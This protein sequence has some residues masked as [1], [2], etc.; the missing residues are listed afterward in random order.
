MSG[1]PKE[2]GALAGARA[3]PPLILVLFHFCEQSGYFHT[4][5][6][7]APIGKGYLWVEF[8]FALSGFVLI[9]AYGARAHT[10]WRPVE[11]LR[12][13]ATRLSRLYPLHL[14]TLLLLA[15]IVVVARTL[16][17]H[18][19]F[20]SVFDQPYHP[21]VTG[22]TFAANLAL[23][24][25]WN[26]Y[27]FLSWNAPSWFVSVEFLLCLLFP[28]FV[29]FSRGGF[30]RGL[31]LVGAGAAGLAAL[32]TTSTQGLDLT[33]HN[34]IYR[35][36]AGF[37]AGIGFAVIFRSLSRSSIRIPDWLL[38]V[39]QMAVLAA[40]LIAIYFEGPARTQKD[41]MVALPV[42][43][44]VFLFAFDRGWL[45]RLMRTTPLL[46]LG[47]WSYAIYLVQYPLL[48]ALRT[49]R[50]F[51]PPAWNGNATVHN[52]EAVC[53]L[54]ACIAAG[55]GLTALIEKPASLALRRLITRPA[56]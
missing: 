39:A 30:L 38:T 34:S 11:Y 37:A 21:I 35:G 6:L 3:L 46:A 40:L 28:V 54:A 32:L 55:A 7:D 27:P 13:L 19:G 52:I 29:A 43:S 8:F 10:L 51:Y 23:V 5:V 20:V 50:Q 4:R 53:L 42:M 31:L 16:A 17:A 14:A 22:A 45:A 24:Q 12:F 49:L 47:E 56:A 36:A 9:H 2:I 44:F 26:L 18:F 25:A 41:L 48:Q 33:F 15:V 1:A